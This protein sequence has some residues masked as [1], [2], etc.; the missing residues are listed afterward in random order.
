[1]NESRLVRI[2][3][4]ISRRSGAIKGNGTALLEID[5]VSQGTIRGTTKED[6]QLG[7][8]HWRKTNWKTG[9]ALCKKDTLLAA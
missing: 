8:G 3:Q 7:G 2:W 1:M 4:R 5:A 6:V 9:E